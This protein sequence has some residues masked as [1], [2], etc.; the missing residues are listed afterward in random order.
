MQKTP[1]HSLTITENPATEEKEDGYDDWLRARLADTIQK[2]D[3]EEMKTSSMAEVRDRLQE[4]RA[5]SIRDY[6]GIARDTYGSTG[7]TINDYFSNARDSW[8]R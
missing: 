3:S 4:K 8:E 2:L 5:A 7:E 1:S 6:I